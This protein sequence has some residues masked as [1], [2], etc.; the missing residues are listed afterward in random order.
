MHRQTSERY[1]SVI[2]IPSIAD[3]LRVLRKNRSIIFMR[4]ILLNYIFA[5]LYVIVQAHWFINYYWLH[6][7]LA[8]LYS[9]H[10]LMHP[11]GFKCP[12]CDRG[13]LVP[14]SASGSS[15]S[16]PSTLASSLECNQCSRSPNALQLLSLGVK[17][18]EASAEKDH[19]MLL[20]KPIE[21]AAEDPLSAATAQKLAKAIAHLERHIQLLRSFHHPNANS[22]GT[23][24]RDEQ[25]AELWVFDKLYFINQF[26]ICN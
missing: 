24:F 17:V 12:H 1:V 13:I 11:K 25:F 5:I 26:K 7:V 16:D 18:A 2:S 10:N 6:T 15:S 20:L 19:A 14:A 23:L 4:Y 9:L 21:A 8:L 3:A 22:I